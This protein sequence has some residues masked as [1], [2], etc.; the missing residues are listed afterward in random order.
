MCLDF[1]SNR[2]AGRDR[3][4][5]EAWKVIR[6]EKGGKFSFPCYGPFRSK[7]NT[8][9]TA[10]VV[11]VENITGQHYNCGF[12]CFETKEGA[13]NWANNRHNVEIV[14]VK[15]KGILARGR[16]RNHSCIVARHILVPKSKI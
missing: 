12:H 5:I 14:K 6:P 15:V 1:V 9:L 11:D 2:Y 4:E 13:Q 10:E 7:R 3:K 8:W 16:Q